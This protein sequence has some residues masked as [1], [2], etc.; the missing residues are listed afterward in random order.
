MIRAALSK[1]KFAKNVL[2]LM[3]GT[4]VAQII[5]LAISPL[6]TRLYSPNE[7]AIFAMYSAILAIFSVIACFRFEIAIPIPKEEKE[8]F[9]LVLLAVISNIFLP[10]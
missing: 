10:F 2:T 6:L 3:T 4:G 7:F 5:P 1:S 8:A 9:E